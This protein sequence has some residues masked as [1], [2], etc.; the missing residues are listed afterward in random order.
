MQYRTLDQA[1]MR[2][3][4]VLLRAGF[5]VP[6][7]HGRVLDAERVRAVLSTMRAILDAGASLILLAHQGR[8][9]GEGFEA[10]FSQ[11]PLVPVLEKLLNVS[12][13]FAPSCV[14]PETLA[15]ALALR[16]GQVLL[17]ENLRF[18]KGEKKNDPAFA[19]ELAHL[20]DLYVNDAFPN[21]HRSDASMVWVAKL[22]PS[23]MG[24][25]CAEEVRHLSSVLEDPRRP[26]TVIIGGAKMETKIPV[27]ASFL[28]SADDILLG[29]TIANTFIAAR[30]FAV[31]RS[32][33][34]PAFVPRAQEFMLEGEK[35]DLADIHVP[36]D[37]VVASEPK[38]GA[39]T[40][41]IPLED[42]EGDMAIYDIGSVTAERYAVRIAASGMVVWNGPVG[43]YEVPTFSRGTRRLAEAIAR[44]T[45]E[46]GV[47]SI[48][49][50]GDTLDFHKRCGLDLSPYS[51]VS[52]GG[53][54]MLEFLSG[55]QFHALEA[56]SL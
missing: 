14:G 22:L 48:V 10:V 19:K 55:R 15:L 25:R 49:G 12:V 23:Y 35:E 21:M 30:G 36:R 45:R 2:G 16:P 3:K 47:A 51:F 9:K 29:G 27:I 41:D 56:L 54:A 42:I 28:T 11:K 20:G 39:A 31:G 34:E 1:D 46:R 44:A 8:P 32:K 43:I 13:A 37:A 18:H 5:D 4:R 17:L 33:Y 52:T 50:G 6:M 26:L 7:E 24:I 38:E 40:L 53:G